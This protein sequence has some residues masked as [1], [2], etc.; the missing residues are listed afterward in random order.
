[1]DFMIPVPVQQESE[2]E[3]GVPELA[4]AMFERNN[5]NLKEKTTEARSFCR[6]CKQTHHHLCEDRCLE[7]HF[8]ATGLESQVAQ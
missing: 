4:V 2:D 6:L 7:K 8:G 3:P 5:L 1:M